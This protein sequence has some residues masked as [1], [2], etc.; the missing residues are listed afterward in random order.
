MEVGPV[1]RQKEGLSE[2]TSLGQ[3]K[4]GMVGWSCSYL[5]EKQPDYRSVS[6]KPCRRQDVSRV[7]VFVFY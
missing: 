1:Y 3:D 7:Y 2:K 5:P 4:K 6:A